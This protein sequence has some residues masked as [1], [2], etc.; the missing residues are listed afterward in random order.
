MRG[1]HLQECPL[2]P[3]SP[4]DARDI[5]HG[6]YVIVDNTSRPELSHLEI[7]E[8]AIEGGAKIIQLRAKN[9]DKRHIYETAVEMKKLCKKSGACFIVNDHLDVAMAVEADGVHLGQ[10]DIPLKAARKVAG[11]KLMIGI[12]THSLQQ[13]VAADKGGADYIGFGAMYATKSKDRP[14]DPQGPERLAEVVKEVSIPV[15][16]IGGITREKIPEIAKTGAQ[17]FAVISAIT[18]APDIRREVERLIKDWKKI[19]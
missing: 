11:R 15:V 4:R 19:S 2:K 18:K 3:V 17:A 12:S 5:I 9:L 16:A 6:L 7:A 14:T 13:A 10:Q 1:I 8:A